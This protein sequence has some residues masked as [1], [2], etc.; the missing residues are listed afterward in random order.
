M[1]SYH[2]NRCPS[3]SWVPGLLPSCFLRASRWDLRREAFFRA[4]SQCRPDQSLSRVSTLP[5]EAGPYPSSLEPPSQALRQLSVQTRPVHPFAHRFGKCL[6]PMLCAGPQPGAGD[7]A[8]CPKPLKAGV[9][10]GEPTQA[11]RQKP[12]KVLLKR[13]SQPGDRLL[14]TGHPQ[15]TLY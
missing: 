5:P 8:Q 3:S 2:G 6:A 12:C 15:R 11:G 13:P 1:R 14:A 10:W 4:V 7:I 9:P